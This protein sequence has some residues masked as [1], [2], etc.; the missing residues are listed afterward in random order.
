MVAALRDQGWDVPD[1]QGN[2]LW[3]PLGQ[4]A[5]PFAQACQQQ[6][7]T[8]RPFAGDGVRCTVAEP[9]ASERL[10]EVAGRWRAERLS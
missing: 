5:V 1:A 3:L 2:F 8:V 7:L 4:D 9:E 10:L 6:G